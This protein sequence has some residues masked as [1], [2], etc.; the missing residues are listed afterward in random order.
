MISLIMVEQF[1]QAWLVDVH[2]RSDRLDRLDLSLNRL[3]RAANR[4]AGA[5]GPALGWVLFTWEQLIRV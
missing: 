5:W 2:D 4:S 1:G 3:S